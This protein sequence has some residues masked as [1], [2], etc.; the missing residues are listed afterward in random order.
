MGC[1]LRQARERREGSRTCQGGFAVKL[2]ERAKY[3]P[4]VT[5]E[6]IPDRDVPAHLPLL[7][8]RVDAITIPALRN[9]ENDPSYPLGFR[10][11]P[12][13]RRVTSALI[14]K[15]TGFEAVPSV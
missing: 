4:I 6:V 11:T 13:T 2:S 14:V 3:H 12:Q 1:D 15:K 8:G 7:D 10:V 5:A 9:G